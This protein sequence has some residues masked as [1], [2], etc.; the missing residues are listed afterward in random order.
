MSAVAWGPF[1]PS[2]RTAQTRRNSTGLQA[3]MF[4]HCYDRA[5]GSRGRARAACQWV[6]INASWRRKR[7]CLETFTVT[8][9]TVME[10]SHV[11]LNKCALASHMMAEKG[12]SAKQLRREL[13]LGSY[14]TARFMCSR[15][16]EAMKRASLMGRRIDGSAK[17]DVAGHAPRPGAPRTS[18]GFEPLLPRDRSRRL[19]AVALA[20][21]WY[22][23]LRARAGA[24]ELR[25][26]LP[27]HPGARRRS[28]PWLA[29]RHQGPRRTFTPRINTMP[30]TQRKGT[31]RNGCLSTIGIPGRRVDGAFLASR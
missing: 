22:P 12:N 24:A 25:L 14:R 30:A 6:G 1:G 15:I 23:A 29:V 16:R 28:C 3:R 20:S 19:L 2:G 31:R 9:G 10:R 17:T 5:N 13:K 8:V 27:P 26:R 4:I 11:P 7:P 18:Y 21:R